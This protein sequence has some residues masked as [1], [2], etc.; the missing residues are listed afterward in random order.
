MQLD[1]PPPVIVAAFDNPTADSPVF[2]V[3]QSSPAKGGD[4]ITLYVSGLGAGLPALPTP[5]TVWIAV[6]SVAMQPVS[7]LP[8]HGDVAQVQFV[9]PTALAYDS[10]TT[11]QTV[12]VSIGTGTRLSAA[13]VLDVQVNPPAAPAT[14]Q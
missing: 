13:Y 12:S 5:D 10:T 6:G 1:A 3:G 7:I 11:R 2:A 9:L 4:T 8:V 14:G